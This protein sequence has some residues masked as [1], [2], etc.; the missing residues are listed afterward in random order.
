MFCNVAV[1]HTRLG[2][3]TYAFNPAD[4]ALAP[5]DCVRVRLRGRKV[6]ALV[7]EVLDKSPVAKTLPVEATPPSSI[8]RSS[9]RSGSDWIRRL[10]PPPPVTSESSPGPKAS[11]VAVPCGGGAIRVG[12]PPSSGTARCET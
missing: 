11:A 1:P 6:K 3:L 10:E 5:G 7:V 2:E 8:R 4:F 9:R 12:A